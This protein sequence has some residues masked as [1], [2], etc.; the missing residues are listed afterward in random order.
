[1]NTWFLKQ[2]GWEPR[3]SSWAGLAGCL[4]GSISLGDVW[5]APATRRGDNSQ[6]RQGREFCHAPAV[7]SFRGIKGALAKGLVL[8]SPPRLS[9]EA[10]ASF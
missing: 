5:V 2:G 9:E 6:L 10:V 8:I 1:M 3:W 7:P 4:L